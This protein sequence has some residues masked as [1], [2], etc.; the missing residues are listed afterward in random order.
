MANSQAPLLAII[1]RG[2]LAVIEFDQLDHCQFDGKKVRFRL[3]SRWSSI[4]WMLHDDILTEECRT[5]RIRENRTFDG[6][7]TVFA[8]REPKSK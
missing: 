5:V 6:F 4:D 3:N 2:A 7:G 8:G 1:E